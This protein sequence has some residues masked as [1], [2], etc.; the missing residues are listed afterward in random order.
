M[1]LMPLMPDP[2]RRLRALTRDALG[3]ALD[4]ALW[5]VNVQMAVIG[6]LGQIV[7]RLSHPT[8]PTP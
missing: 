6:A 7:R 5:L 2:I 4:A 1:P 3:L 8:T